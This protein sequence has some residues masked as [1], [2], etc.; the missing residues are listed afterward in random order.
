MAKRKMQYK[1]WANLRPYHR[2]ELVKRYCPRV[3]EEVLKA[4]LW[5]VKKDGE[6]GRGNPK[7]LDRYTP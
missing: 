2:V 6:L 1:S 4:L 3:D 7:L 5:P